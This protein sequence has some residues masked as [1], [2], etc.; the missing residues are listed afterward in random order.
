M[1]LEATNDL[2]G[3][4]LLYDEILLKNPGNQ[5]VSKRLIA[6]SIAKGELNEAITALNEYLLTFTSD[7]SAWGQLAY[8][9]LEL[10]D[11]KQAVFCYE[12]LCLIS[13]VNCFYLLRLGELY[14]TLGGL[15]N[16]KVA[17]GYYAQALE[18]NSECTRAIWGIFQSCT[19]IAR[20][21]GGKDDT[22]NKQ[23]L[24]KANKKLSDAYRAGEAV[25]VLV[26][27]VCK[28]SLI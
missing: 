9:Y 15:E 7:E 2:N 26:E 25:K 23:M 8:L 1:F 27:N 6:I 4:S 14:Y 13:P 3:A 5:A 11:I 22:L 18:S 19:F 20:T 16:V 12:E 24:E 17:R 21:K 10:G 28:N